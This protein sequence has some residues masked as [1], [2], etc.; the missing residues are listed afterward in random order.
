MQGIVLYPS[1]IL[2]P[3]FIFSFLDKKKTKEDYK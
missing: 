2:F 1:V 3:H